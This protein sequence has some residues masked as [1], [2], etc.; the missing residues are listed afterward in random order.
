YDRA[1]VEAAYRFSRPTPDVAN[2]A[3]GA[4]DST[5]TTGS[6]RS[7]DPTIAARGSPSRMREQIPGAASA[8]QAIKRPPEVCGSVSKRCRQ[9][10]R[11]TGKS[12]PSPS[13]DQLSSD[14]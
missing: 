9:S 8:S 4:Q 5:T 3:G 11:P 7:T 10:S 14:E 1:L 12:T 2:N 13:L 6:P